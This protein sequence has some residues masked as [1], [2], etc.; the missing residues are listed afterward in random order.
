MRWDRRRWRLQATPEPKSGNSPLAGVSCSSSKLCVAVGDYL[1]SELYDPTAMHTLPVLMPFAER[2]DGVRWS[3]LPF[4]SLPPGGQQGGLQAVSCTSRGACMAVGRFF[5]ASDGLFGERWDGSHW[6]VERMPDPVPAMMISAQGAPY[7]GGLSCSSSRACTVVG[8]YDLNHSGVGQTFAERW[9]GSSWSV[10]STPDVEGA[11]VTELLGVSC[12][13]AHACIA[14]GESDRTSAPGGGRTL[15]ERWNG[16][17]WSIEKTPDASGGANELVGV[18]CTSSLACTAVGSI[19]SSS[20]FNPLVEREVGARWSIEPAWQASGDGVQLQAISCTSSV[21]CTAVA[22]TRINGVIAEQSA[23]A[24]RKAD[25]HA[26]WARRLTPMRVDQDL[27]SVD[28]TDRTVGA[29]RPC[30]PRVQH[31]SRFATHARRRTGVRSHASSSPPKVAEDNEQ[32]RSDHAS[33]IL[34]LK[35]SDA[36][37]GHRADKPQLTP[38][39]TRWGSARRPGP[40]LGF[41]PNLV[42]IGAES[43]KD[44]AGAAVARPYD[45]D[46]DVLGA[47]RA[48]CDPVRGPEHVLGL[49]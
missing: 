30:D 44:V 27:S 31:D 48:Q 11:F 20:G 14:V 33:S 32:A 25:R 3:L 24:R 29:A 17:T 22:N 46:Q 40:L 6:L 8:S 37:G 19:Q 47:R 42:R 1:Q 35:F 34:E 36:L 16:T 2:W 13:S 49:R 28:A 43:A 10:E 23:P 18:S 38:R 12:A 45:H 39:R 15:A 7:I 41:E 26:L 5:G 9:D 21:V 4:P